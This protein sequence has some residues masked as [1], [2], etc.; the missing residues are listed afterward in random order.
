MLA[1]VAR[2]EVH[3]M[4]LNEFNNN[5]K[6]AVKKALIAIVRVFLSPILCIVPQN[7]FCGATEIP[8]SVALG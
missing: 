3:D 2:D 1:V 5:K 4:L 6:F 8:A 7:S